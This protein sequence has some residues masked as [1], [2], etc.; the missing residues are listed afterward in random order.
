MRAMSTFSDTQLYADFIIA[1][2]K[3]LSFSFSVK[4]NL[5]GKYFGYIDTVSV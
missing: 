4:Y 2:L 5:I 1:F 3:L